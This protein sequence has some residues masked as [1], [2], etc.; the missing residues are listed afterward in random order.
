MN[1][2]E[3]ARAAGVHHLAMS[4]EYL[5]GLE[6]LVAAAVAAEREACAKV[7]EDNALKVAA[8]HFR[9]GQNDYF[10]GDYFARAIRARGQA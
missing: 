3:L 8:G 5:P 4:E 10:G 1:T 9:R 7:C 6:R 2:T